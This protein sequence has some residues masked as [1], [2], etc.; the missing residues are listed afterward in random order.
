I[1]VHDDDLPNLELVLQTSEVSEG[2]GIYATKATLRRTSTGNPV[3]FTANI[4]ASLSNTLILPGTVTL[5]ANENEKTFNVGVIDNAQAEGQRQVTITASVYVSSCGCSAPPS[6]AGSVSANLTINDNDGPSLTLTATPLTL[7]EGAANAGTLRVARNTSTTA[8]L[9]VDLSTS[10]SSEAVLP[11][12]ATIPAG[13]AFVDVPVTTIN[14]NTTDGSQ[15]VYFEAKATGFSTGSV[16]VVVTDQNKP[17]LTIPAVSLSDTSVQALNLFN[18]NVSVKNN[19]L[20]TAP[21][22]A[23]VYGYLSKDDVID[24]KDSL[25]ITGTIATAIPVGQTAA[26][27]GAVKAPNV[28]G[29]YK[30]LFKVNPESAMTELLLTNNTAQPVALNIKPDYSATAVVQPTYF[31]KGDTVR[32][33]GTAT[34]VNGAAAVGVPVEVYIITQ[35][36]RRTV[37]ATTNNAGQ[38]STEFV[39]MVKEYGHYTVGASFPGMNLTDE[40]DAFDI[41]GV[42][43]ND[44]NLPSF[45]VKLGETLT[46]TMKVQNLSNKALTNLSLKPRTL[47]NGAVVSF[48]TLA[49][50]AGNATANFH[51]KVSGTALTGGSNYQVG[52]LQAVANEG[53]IQDQNFDYYC[54]AQNAQLQADIS[55]IDVKLSQAKG[56]QIVEFRVV[57]R[58]SG[59]SGEVTVQLPQVNWLRSITP[60]VLSS[61]STGDT[62]I[63]IVKFLALAE[64]PFEYPLKGSIAINCAN[65]NGIAVPFTFEKVS[66]STGVAR[67]TVTD[68]FSYYAQGG[69][70]VEGAHVII[71]NYFTGVVYAEGMSNTAGQFITQGGIPE[72]KHRVVVEKDKHQ[73]YDGTI[74]INPGDSV[75]KEVFLNYQAITFNWSVVPTTVQDQYDISLNAQFET[76]VPMPVV[77]M[78]MPKTLPQL[79]GT[80]TYAFN[81]VV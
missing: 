44:G 61:L 20:A 18:Y 38:Y 15:T 4:S 5:A 52:V 27:L 75:D 57:N 36:F 23:V 73:S 34:K 14:D 55:K 62:A 46:G 81:I 28:P 42:K 59:A 16:W 37:T 39:P 33:S 63:V 12:T 45:L 47:P 31:L 72:G 24:A 3:A 53:N 1:T 22:G 32:I 26:L 66:T 51:Y 17:D 30:L 2:G 10:D 6:T 35:G 70:K 21:M 11:A 76:H 80:E 64:V 19:G 67:I 65:G 7:P 56:E 78:T 71:K 43:L 48:D 79:S 60:K 69:P 49:N 9:T 40:Q 58:G 8:A 29:R 54:K 13:K 41:L 77:T 25:L 74:T 50:L 68:Q